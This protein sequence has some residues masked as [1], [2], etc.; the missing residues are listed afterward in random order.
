MS[1]CYHLGFVGEACGVELAFSRAR[2]TRALGKG[3]PFTPLIFQVISVNIRMQ[4]IYIQV[5]IIKKKLISNKLYLWG[6]KIPSGW[7]NGII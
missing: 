3:S 1:I 7:E 4:V 2:I 6:W 5:P